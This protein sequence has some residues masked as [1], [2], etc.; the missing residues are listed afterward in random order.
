MQP[1]R[2][3]PVQT[4][5]AILDAAAAEFSIHGYAG[6]GIGAIISRA[7]L[8]KGAL[9]HHFPD[10]RSL[11]M[12]W[13]EDRLEPALQ[14]SWIQPLEAIHSL[15]GLVGL[16]RLRC[17]EMRAGDLTAALVMLGCGASASEPSLADAVARVFD[18]WRAAIT[19][20]LERGKTE[21]WIHPSIR[22]PVEAA[23]MVSAFCGFSA[24][25]QGV[26]DEPVLRHCATAAEAYLETLR[27][28]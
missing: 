17:M 19:A 1:R 11:A 27:A 25:H 13:I 3:Q 7:G 10:K 23:F 22:P 8:T 24:S 28:Q 21:G 14:E 6:T 4:R 16:V 15:G 26:P 20:V 2:K 18:Q 5:Q 12:A 9:F